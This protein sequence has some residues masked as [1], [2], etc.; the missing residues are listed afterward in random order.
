MDK[1]IKVALVGKM[2]SGKDTVAKYLMDDYG[3]KKFYFAK[4]IE[5]IILKYF[6]NAFD[7]GKP[8]QYYQ[9][10]GQQLR[11]LDQDVWINYLLNE[12]EIL[13][14]PI[15]I[16]VTDMRQVNE[17]ERLK[18]EGFTIIKVVADEKIRIDRILKSGDKFNAED[19]HH[20]TELQV[21]LINADIT[22]VNN[23]TIEELKKE[24][25]NIIKKII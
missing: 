2:R 24:V 1:Q 4:G 8:R 6:P 13:K 5:E 15:N 21:D 25:Q 11:V 16:V 19:L 14:D 9:H 23:G 3:F 7:N 12:V 10:I 22:V 18:K 17:A 20:E